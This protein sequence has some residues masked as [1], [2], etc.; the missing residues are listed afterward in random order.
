MHSISFQWH[1]PFNL[2]ASVC[3]CACACEE[4][5]P[6]NISGIHNYSYFA[7]LVFERAE[8]VARNFVTNVSDQQWRGVQEKE[9]GTIKRKKGL[10]K[11]K[12]KIKAKA[13]CTTLCSLCW[14]HKICVCSYAACF[15]T[16]HPIEHGVHE[17]THRF[18]ALS[19]ERK[20]NDV[21]FGIDRFAIW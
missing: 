4:Q 12:Q 14:Q 8:K 16:D 2:C 7:P 9:R 17:C 11:A 15:C 10:K 13:F 1:F 18:I 6:L 3:A 21:Y 19:N 20:R 5:S